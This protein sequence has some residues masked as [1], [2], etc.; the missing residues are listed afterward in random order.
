MNNTD[1]PSSPT[2]TGIGNLQNKTW[3]GEAGSRYNRAKGGGRF[4]EEKE[5]R[6]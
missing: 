4:E 2:P 3:T 5:H 6:K 1:R